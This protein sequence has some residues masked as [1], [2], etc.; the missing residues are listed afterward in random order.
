MIHRG[1]KPK[2]VMMIV[3]YKPPVV[4]VRFYNTLRQTRGM[5]LMLNMGMTKNPIWFAPS[6]INYDLLDS[7]RE[8][9]KRVAETLPPYFTISNSNFRG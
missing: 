6:P 9:V 3:R 4:N 2:K 8:W 5:G 7:H 1:V